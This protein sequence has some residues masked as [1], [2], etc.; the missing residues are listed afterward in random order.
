M[1]RTVDDW[2]REIID[3][4]HTFSFV[5]AVEIVNKSPAA[6]KVRLILGAEFFIQFYVNV[7]TG[8]QNFV[9]VLGRQRLYARD[10]VD[11]SW[12]RH[13]YEDPDSHDFSPE[14]A[15]P[16]SVDEFLSEV[17]RILTEAELL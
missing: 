11:G 4:A 6:L 7:V 9:V 13:P 17:Q 8:T 12:H 14:G 16:I 1:P 10:C 15:R 3:A 5:H 2:E